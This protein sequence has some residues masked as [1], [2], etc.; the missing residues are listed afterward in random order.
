M[1]SGDAPD[2][3]AAVLRAPAAVLRARKGFLH[4]HDFGGWEILELIWCPLY[5]NLKEHEFGKQE[6]R[7]PTATTS[8]IPQ[9]IWKQIQLHRHCQQKIPWGSVELMPTGLYGSPRTVRP[10][11]TVIGSCAGMLGGANA[12]G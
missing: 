12:T 6:G 3:P 1:G 11:V 5:E 7:N 10:G 9:D 4:F 2:K 8:A